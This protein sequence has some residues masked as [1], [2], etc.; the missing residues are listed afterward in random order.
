MIT[1]RHAKK[2]QARAIQFQANTN[3]GTI[4]GLEN[5]D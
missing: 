3:Q 1:P 4:P 5:L 2:N